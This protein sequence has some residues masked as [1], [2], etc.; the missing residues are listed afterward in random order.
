M[1]EIIQVDITTEPVMVTVA[2]VFHTIEVAG[3]GVPGPEGPAGPSGSLPLV[4]AQAS[5]AAEWIITHNRGY[6]PDVRLFVE[7]D[8]TEQVFTDVVFVDDNQVI[9][10]WPS[11]ESGEAIIS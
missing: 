9:V 4:Y 3:V 5:P 11:P 8:L 10:Q 1:T 2:P 7:P 6:K